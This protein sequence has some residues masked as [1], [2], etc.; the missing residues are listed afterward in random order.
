VAAVVVAV[1]LLPYT[2][3]SRSWRF[4]PRLMEYLKWWRLIRCEAQWQGYLLLVRT[5]RS[6][7][8]SW[9]CWTWWGVRRQ[10]DGGMSW[11]KTNSSGAPDTR[12]R[13]RAT[14]ES[15]PLPASLTCVTTPPM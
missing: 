2:R 8:T 12:R 3:L 5:R 14:R 11:K 1:P 7:R 9:G 13:A 6:W 4:K 15:F 10:S